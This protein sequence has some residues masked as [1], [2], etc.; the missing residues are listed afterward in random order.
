MRTGQ[1]V[2][3]VSAQDNVLPADLETADWVGAG[4]LAVGFLALAVLTRWLVVRLVG[5]GDSE[6]GAGVVF[7]R[8]AS[9]VVLAIGVAY[10]LVTLGARIGPLLGALGVGGI[11]LAFAL[12]DVLQNF[13]AGVL[14]QLRRPFRRGDQ[15]KLDEYEGVVRD[16]NL[17]TVQL[18]TYDGLVV[19]L[20]NSAVLQSPI[21]NYT[22]TPLNRT[23]LLVGVAYDTD[24]ALARDVLLRAVTSAPEVAGEPPAEVWA[25]EFADSAITFAVRYW[26]PSDIATRWRVRSAVAVDAKRA[27]DAAGVTIPFPQRTLWYGDAAAASRPPQR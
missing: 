23:E 22:R 26:H 11:A 7:G 12:Q 25:Y 6:P 24:L 5:R 15:V 18:H 16:I 10:V 20:P 4:L 9:L 19:Y 1:L 27:L 21:V 3:A 13:V 2:A 14:L 8:F 17:R